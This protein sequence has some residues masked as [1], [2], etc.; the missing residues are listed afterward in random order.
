MV[1]SECHCAA[2][3][4]RVRDAVYHVTSRGNAR[5]HRYTLKKAAEEVQRY[6]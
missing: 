1:Q 6:L 4:V 5:V 2:V 3:A